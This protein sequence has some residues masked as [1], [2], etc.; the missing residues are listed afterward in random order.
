MK[1]QLGERHPGFGR[2]AVR[3][4]LAHEIGQRLRGLVVSVRGLGEAFLQQ[5]IGARL[6][7]RSAARH[8]LRI[9]EESLLVVLLKPRERSIEKR[10]AAKSRRPARSSARAKYH[11]ASARRGCAGSFAQRLS[12]WLEAWRSAR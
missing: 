4:E 6:I 11:W 1:S 9:R 7:V 8:F 5:K 2:A 12:S 3:G 10:V